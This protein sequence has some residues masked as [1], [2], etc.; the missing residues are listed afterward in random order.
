MKYVDAHCHFLSDDDIACARAGGAHGFVVNATAS[1]DWVRVIEL[2]QKWPDVFPAIGMHPWRVSD[3]AAGWDGRMYDILTS[4]PKCMVG[5]IG[6]DKN[7]PDIDAQ[8][9]IF[10]AQMSMARE[11]SR[12]AHIHCVGA[13]DRLMH[14]ITC[15]FAP[16]VVMHSYSGHA[17]MIGRLARHNV[18]FSYSPAILN[19]ARRKMAAAVVATPLDRILV[20]SDAAS[21]AMPDM[22]RTIGAI[23]ELRGLGADRM[24]EILFNNSQRMLTHG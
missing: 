1:A 12:V 8:Y 6:L 16:C 13:W 14:V 23:A 3:A 11:L 5:E 10:W 9:R 22:Q 19:T 2:S 4:N 15:N 20:E 7:H 17:D 18:Y 21:C 24:T